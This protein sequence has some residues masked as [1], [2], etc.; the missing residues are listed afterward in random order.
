MFYLYSKKHLTGKTISIARP[1][2]ILAG[3]EKVLMTR[4]IKLKLNRV[5]KNEERIRHLTNKMKACSA[6]PVVTMK[7][8]NLELATNFKYW[9][10]F[11]QHE[12]A[13]LN[14]EISVTELEAAIAREW[15][16]EDRYRAYLLKGFKSRI[17]EIKESS[18]RYKLQMRS[19][20][21]YF[22]LYRDSIISSS[23][24]RQQS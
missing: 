16:V 20:K 14:Y 9:V 23:I 4:E 12:L 22:T 3:Y 10:S 1:G 19:P 18:L 7:T 17:R 21:K 8:H 5:L 2:G 15:K 24:C 11:L 6:R 13:I